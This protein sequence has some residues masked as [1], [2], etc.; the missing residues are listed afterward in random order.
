M[1]TRLKKIY[2]EY[3]S[4][5]WIVVSVSF[6]DRVGG[7]MLFPFFSDARPLHGRIQPGLGDPG[8]DWARTGRFD[9]RQL[10]PQPALVPGRRPLPACRAWLFGITCQV[11]VTR[12]LH[13]Y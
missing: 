1:F 9:S 11:G 8:H 3:P 6:I 12:A 7:T 10:Q 5:F 2:Q 13:A 4:N